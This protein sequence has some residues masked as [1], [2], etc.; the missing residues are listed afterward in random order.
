MN[1]IRLNALPYF[2][3][4]LNS[5]LLFAFRRVIASG[6]FLE[7]DENR[8]LA[9][10]LRTLLGG[11]H[12]IPL[13]SGHDAIV[14]AIKA[15]GVG[16]TDEV[17]VPAIAYPTAFA[18]WQSS[19]TIVPADVDENGQLDPR[20]LRAALTKRTKAVIAVHL[21]GHIG[22]M[23]ALTSFLQKK[24]IPL[25]EDCCQAFGSQFRKKSVG[26]LG[27]IGCFSFYPTKTVGALG[28][29][30]AVRTNKKELREYVQQAKLYGEKVR[31]HSNFPSFHSTLPE[32]QAAGLLVYLRYFKDW[33]QKRKTL[34]ATYES[35]LPARVRILTSH[36]DADPVPLELV[37][38]A[39]KRDKLA[40]Y[41]ARRGIETVVHY[42][43]PFPFVPAFRSLGYKRGSFPTA[44]RL[45]RRILS[46]PLHHMMT[47][48]D[49]HTICR[50][51]DSFYAA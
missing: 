30:G 14:L 40:T 8:A 6:R 13:A 25:I 24:R 34:L 50:A 16:P 29:G 12:V 51:I 37:I 27:D 21:Y 9:A 39:P 45:S 7:G 33:A 3:I 2:S 35:G 47:Q 49:V 17:I 46:L 44:E 19:A 5:Q 22:D 1:R 4:R 23:P 43:T 38:E 10:H 48:K 26:T 41:L 36:P 15:L 20:A 18:A 11:G 42:P 28:N 31:Y 32:M